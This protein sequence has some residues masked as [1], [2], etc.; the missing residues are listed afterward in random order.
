[1]P[2]DED[3]LTR[4]QSAL[5]ICRR[6]LPQIVRGDLLRVVASLIEQAPAEATV[7]V[8]HSAVLNYVMDQAQRN[9]FARGMLA[10]GCI[11]ISNE[12]PLVFPQFL[13]SDARQP[14]G[15]FLLCADGQALAWT[16]PHGAA[17]QRL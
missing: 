17:L 3:R 6:E 12:S 1:M 14:S 7:V 4:R 10:S 9:E 11:W 5:R 13:P 2:D 8:Y 15:M 16:D